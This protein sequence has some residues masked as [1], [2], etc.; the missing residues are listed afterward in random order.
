MSVVVE[1][2]MHKMAKELLYKEIEEKS[3][4]EYKLSNGTIG[5]ETLISREDYRDECV[6]MEFPTIDGTY[7]DECGCTQQIIPYDCKNCKWNDDC[8]FDHKGTPLD[9]CGRYMEDLN[10]FRC[11]KNTHGFRFNNG[12]GYC[13]CS[14][15][16]LFDFNGAKTHDIA[17]FWKGSVTFAIEIINK[18]EPDWIKKSNDLYY[19]VFLV[20]A[21]DILKRIDNTPIYVYCIIGRGH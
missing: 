6:L 18:H 15:C 19:N 11:K 20:R 12:K 14:D 9:P 17:V 5:F 7:P 21:A 3:G 4:F 2:Y 1:S 13:K 8:L 16:D 10:I